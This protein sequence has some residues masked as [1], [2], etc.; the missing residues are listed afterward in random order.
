M[1]ASNQKPG[2][3]LASNELIVITVPKSVARFLA[4]SRN[5]NNEITYI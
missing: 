5:K 4:L 1:D 3:N 2:A